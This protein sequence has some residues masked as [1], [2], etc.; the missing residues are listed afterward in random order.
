MRLLM[1]QYVYMTLF[2]HY[3]WF[4]FVCCNASMVFVII[5]VRS[6]LY[7]DDDMR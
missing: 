1:E 3:I 7:R 2:T 4:D 6:F 5:G